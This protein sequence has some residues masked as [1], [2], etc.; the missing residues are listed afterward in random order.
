MSGDQVV[1]AGDDLQAHTQFLEPI[2][3]L[4]H[5]WFWRIK[6]QEKSNKA[7][8]FFVFGLVALL[9]FDRLDG[10]PQHPITLSA[11]IGKAFF[12]VITGWSVQLFN[13]TIIQYCST[14][15]QRIFE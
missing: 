2:D 10:H 5:A 11:P 15:L 6:K 7:H 8:G 9:W 14:C 1:I 13:L 3:G 4:L 12:Q